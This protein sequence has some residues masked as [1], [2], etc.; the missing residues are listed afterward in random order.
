MDARP[1]TRQIHRERKAPTPQLPRGAKQIVLPMTRA[2]YDE[3]WHHADRMR[4]F[5]AECAE[6]APELFPACFAQGYSLHGM[7][8]VSR[9]SSPG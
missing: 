5:L 1:Q 6:A 8:R 9:A 3:L 7:G 4:A 2:Q